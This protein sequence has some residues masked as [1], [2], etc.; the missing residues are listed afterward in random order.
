M[1]FNST[2]VLYKYLVNTCGI[3]ISINES[4]VFIKNKTNYSLL[5]K[6][7]FT[8]TKMANTRSELGW[9]ASDPAQPTAPSCGFWSTRLW[10]AFLVS[11]VCGGD[12]P[13]QAEQGKVLWLR[14]GGGGLT[15]RSIFCHLFARGCGFKES[16]FL[17]KQNKELRRT[18]L[19]DLDTPKQR[20]P[21]QEKLWGK[22]SL[23]SKTSPQKRRREAGDGQR[24][25]W[26]TIQNKKTPHVEGGEATDF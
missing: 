4:S 16:N 5:A 22:R 1:G 8:S 19:D 2:K 14:R 10:A 18:G 24:G 12:G 26:T 23:N 17:Q 25:M 20:K 13:S 15:R 7:A 3:L 9:W 11:L 6:L 21:E